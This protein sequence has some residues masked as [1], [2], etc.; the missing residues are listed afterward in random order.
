M[1]KN[2]LF[3]HYFLAFYMSHFWAFWMNK[4]QIGNLMCWF[5][6][7]FDIFLKFL[8]KNAFGTGCLKN[9][10]W[11]FP[12]LSILC[13]KM[14]NLFVILDYFRCHI[15][16]LFERR[17]WQFN[18]QILIFEF[19]Q[20]CVKKWLICCLFWPFSMFHFWAFWTNKLTI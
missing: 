9:S 17:N 11:I 10:I 16:E 13:E 6:C 14:V 18:V 7:N 8:I 4:L 3:F 12:I 19:F 1:W 2:R 5:C 15:L 20:F